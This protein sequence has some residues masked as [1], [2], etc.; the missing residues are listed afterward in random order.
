MNET[1]L[2]LLSGRYQ[3]ALGNSVAKG[4]GADAHEAEELGREAL[5]L[6]LETLDMAKI[7]DKA[8]AA[9]LPHEGDPGLCE[10]MTLRAELFFN[11]AITPIEKTHRAA[12]EAS[13]G[14][15]ELT[16]TLGQKTQDLA[17][18]NR[19]LQ[20]GIVERKTAEKALKTSEHNSAVL[21]KESRLLE[22]H[23]QG[24]ARQILAANETERKKMSLQLKDEIAQTLLGIHVRLLALKKEAASNHTELLK[25]IAI[26]ERLVEESVKTI[27]EL[28][29]EFGFQHEG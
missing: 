17:Q 3:A 14:L 4:P 8:L 20:E 7:H 5:A 21:L 13:A 15:E 2:N 25:E 18:S 9:I 29:R 28:T 11:E 12:R 6:G 19:E 1:N 22:A 23:L 27:N 26:T 10:D 16:A 24:L